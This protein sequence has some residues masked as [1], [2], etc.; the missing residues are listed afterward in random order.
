MPTSGAAS[1]EDHAAAKLLNRMVPAAFFFRPSVANWLV[2][3]AARTWAE[4]NYG[5]ARIYP[6]ACLALATITARGDHATGYRAA[7][8]A[9]IVG[10]NTE[11]GVET[12]RARHVFG[13]FNCHWLEPLEH[14]LA[15]AHQAYDA[16]LRSGELEFACYTF[17]TSQAALL[18][19]ATN[20]ADLEAENR[21]ALD[22]AGKTG[23][24]HA[25]E[26]YTAF[27]G[28][29][30]SLSA[31]FAMEADEI[32]ASNPMAACFHHTTRALA[33]CLFGDD[34]SH[35]QHAEAA[36]RLVP[37]ITGFYP[38]ALI[39]VLESLALLTRQRSGDR[40]PALAERVAANQDWLAARAAEA[41]A[42]FGHL[43]DL[44][45]AERL[46]AAGRGTE[47]LPVYERA[48]RRAKAHQRPWHTALAV[49]KAARCYLA[50]DLEHAGHRLLEQA[51]TLYAEWG[52][53]RKSAALAA[54]FPF[55]QATPSGF[56]DA[57]PLFAA[58]Q[59][60]A[61]LRSVPQLAAATA[62]I[63]QKLSGATDGQIL[64]LD[65]Q[66]Q[67]MLKAGFSADGPMDRQTL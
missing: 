40:D 18:E 32:P 8:A 3:H 31:D 25:T 44:V 36:V 59:Q 49:E 1:A 48:I 2:V 17:F 24:R 11:R 47:A 26:S 21:R 9:L 65:E 12:A 67:W 64:V 57:Q 42:N 10:D 13:L 46:A 50:L 41:P 5:D 58:I 37:Y 60:L 52:A 62:E 63:L 4:G 27:R 43:H 55:L 34:V 45:E 16:L 33:A 38:T 61:S 39:N 30:A 29:I 19:T 6:M 35:A 20:L 7:R 54:E 22:F 15:Q 14:G 51:C 66:D 23:N 28:L 56:R 53:T